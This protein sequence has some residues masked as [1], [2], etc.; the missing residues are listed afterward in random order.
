LRYSASIPFSRQPCEAPQPAGLD[1]EEAFDVTFLEANAM[2]RKV[3]SFQI[4]GLQ[5][6]ALALV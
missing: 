4:K 6:N 3:D 2:L 5:C 1:P